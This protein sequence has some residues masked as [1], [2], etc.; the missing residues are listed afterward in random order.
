MSLRLVTDLITIV[1]VCERGFVLFHVYR[2]L[3]NSVSVYYDMTRRHLPRALL[4]RACL[5]VDPSFSRKQFFFKTLAPK[6]M[7]R[8]NLFIIAD[9]VRARGKDV[10]VVG[11]MRLRHSP[12]LALCHSPNRQ[13]F[14]IFPHS[15][16]FIRYNKQLRSKTLPLQSPTLMCES[17]HT[18][19]ILLLVLSNLGKGLN[20]RNFWRTHKAWVTRASISTRAS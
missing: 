15:P 14:H 1:A 5:D 10:K 18:T 12:A 20:S 6:A 11:V 19:Q 13:L 16:L 17:S 3:K 9:K 4:I 7:F 8:K 2:Q